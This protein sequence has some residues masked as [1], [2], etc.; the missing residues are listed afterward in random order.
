[1]TR[2][3]WRTTIPDQ[4]EYALT[5]SDRRWLR[6]WED[7]LAANFS[8]PDRG[9]RPSSRGRCLTL[10]KQVAPAV[11]KMIMEAE[12]AEPA[13]IIRQW[14]GGETRIIE[15][16]ERHEDERQHNSVPEI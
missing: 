13:R 7:R 3:M 8:V 1:V 11:Y 4:Q 5:A 2:T 14:D 12:P 9:L 10:L 6:F 16:P 15:V